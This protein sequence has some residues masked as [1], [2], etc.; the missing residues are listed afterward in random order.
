MI[1]L[2]HRTEMLLPIL[3]PETLNHG[4]QNRKASTSKQHVVYARR[5]IRVIKQESVEEIAAKKAQQTAKH[6]KRFQFPF[7]SLC[8]MQILV[9]RIN[10]AKC[11]NK[12]RYRTIRGRSKTKWMAFNV[13]LTTF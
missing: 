10:S 12:F 4:P 6:K 8:E 1:V 11:A 5:N 7:F 13:R 2:D 9:W 3:V